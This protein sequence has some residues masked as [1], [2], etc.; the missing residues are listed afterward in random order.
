MSGEIC[1]NNRRKLNQIFEHVE[2]LSDVVDKLRMEIDLL[3]KA[4]LNVN[5]K[6]VS[7]EA[8]AQTKIITYSLQKNDKKTLNCNYLSNRNAMKNVQT[9]P[10]VPIISDKRSVTCADRCTSKLLKGHMKQAFL[11]NKAR[12]CKKCSCKEQCPYT[13]YKLP[14]TKYRCNTSERKIDKISD[15]RV[16]KFRKKNNFLTFINADSVQYKND[17]RFA[18][19]PPIKQKVDESGTSSLSVNLE[20]NVSNHRNLENI[21]EFFKR[22]TAR[23][24][25]INRTRKND[26]LKQQET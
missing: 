20:I 23:T 2:A 8:F 7:F 6:N 14:C 10:L 5:Q 21:N 24:Y 26:D 25:I 12:K 18:N 22:R 17:R 13:L 15:T 16:L 4:F 11:K 19:F 1:H 3:K 9:S